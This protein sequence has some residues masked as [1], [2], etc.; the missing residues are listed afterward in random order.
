[1][2]VPRPG[3]LAELVRLPAVL[4]V[5]GDT[6]AGAA[7][8]AGWRGAALGASSALQY[9][10]GMAL[11]DWADRE[12]DAVERPGRP[13]PSGRVPAPLA[14]AV[15]AGLTAA[16]V[17]VAWRLGG[18]R[19]LAVA[20]PLAAAVWAYD[21]ALKDTPA[22]PAAMT[23]CRALDVLL[24]AS[25]GG[26]A[27]LLRAVPAAALV[28][29]HTATVTTVSRHEVSGADPGLLRRAAAATA[30]VGAA[31]AWLAWARR[32]GEGLR[33]ARTRRLVGGGLAGAY[34]ATVGRGW[35][36]AAREG[37]DAAAVQRAVGGGVVGV[38]A[39]QAALI[40]GRGGVL[41]AMAVAAALP[42]ARILARRRS[43]T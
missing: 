12:V 7:A 30:V 5:P 13:I 29:A 1:M 14:L 3:D 27:G 10:G 22:G 43:V 34:T 40:A 25:V 18:R 21:L 15:G 19:A 6:L 28:G 20:G 4:S 38:T 36:Q 9:L 2:T 16:G 23:A 17:G 42:V 39:L 35:L 33:G 11:N 41:P 26:P 31:A 8:S 24:G 37:G 32:P